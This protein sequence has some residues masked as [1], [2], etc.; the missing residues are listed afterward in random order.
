MLERPPVR[1]MLPCNI[2]VSAT[3]VAVFRLCG[4]SSETKFRTFVSTPQCCW[5]TDEPPK[6]THPGGLL[7]TWL[8]ELQARVHIVLD[9]IPTEK[10]DVIYVRTNI[11]KLY[12]S[13]G[14]ELYSRSTYCESIATDIHDALNYKKQPEGPPP[15]M[16]GILIEITEKDMKR[17]VETIFTENRRPSGKLV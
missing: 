14:N 17:C 11:R 1:R 2:R 6:G 4:E 10:I 8:R 12:S 13:L 15:E 16:R 9:S 5:E 3:W 7:G